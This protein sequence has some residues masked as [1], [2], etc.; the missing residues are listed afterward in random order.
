M[1]SFAQ[2]PVV[3]LGMIWLAAQ[4]VRETWSVKPQADKSL[5]GDPP[6]QVIQASSW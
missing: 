3:S 1:E 6:Q 4:A 2:D 5:D